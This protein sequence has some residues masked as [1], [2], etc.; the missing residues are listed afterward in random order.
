MADA[1]CRQAGA[2]HAERWRAVRGDKTLRLDYDLDGSSVVFDVGG[3]EG[4]WASDIVAMYACTVHVFEPVP[5]YFDGISRRFARNP[6]VVVHP[7]GLAART[8]SE[9]MRIAGNASS[10]FGGAG[11][12]LAVELVGITEFMQS[13]RI[14]RIDLLKIN[15]EGGEYELLDHLLQ[16]G[17]DM[18]TD[19]QVQFHDF[20]PDAAERRRQIQD[21]LS[22][23]HVVTYQ[24]P[25]VWENWRRKLGRPARGIADPSLVAGPLPPTGGLREER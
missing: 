20:V 9:T 14:E 16:H 19:I 24:F 18:I 25:F 8:R 21:R 1:L 12:T 7:F 3:Y 15:I 10:V 4:Q 23:T 5:Q 2:S 13:A 11:P 6:R 17:V 22:D